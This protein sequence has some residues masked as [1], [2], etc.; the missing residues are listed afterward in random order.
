GYFAEVVAV[1]AEGGVELA[2]GQVA[3]QE[4]AVAGVSYGHDLSAAL[5]DHAREP[6]VD[7]EGVE[8]RVAVDAASE[9]RVDRAV[10]PEVAEGRHVIAAL[11][12]VVADP[13]VAGH[14]VAPVQAAYRAPVVPHEEEERRT[15]AARRAEGRVDGQVPV[16]GPVLGG[17]GQGEGGEEREAEE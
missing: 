4:Q 3:R 9:R 16:D 12:P 7:A 2:V 10:C 11:L 5:H 13:G 14:V 1:R 17:G 8:H 15:R 6:G